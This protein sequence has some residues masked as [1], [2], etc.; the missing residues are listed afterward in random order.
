MRFFMFGKNML[1]CDEN[2]GNGNDLGGGEGE[3]DNSAEAIAAAA[4]KAKADEGKT[5]EEIKVA[6]DAAAE[7]AKAD[8]GKTPEEIKAAAEKAKADEGKTP[9]EIKAAEEAA[10]E[11]AKA[12]EEGKGAPENYEAFDLPAEYDGVIDEQTMEGFSEVAKELDLSQAQA[13][14]LVD[15]EVQRQENLIDAYQHQADKWTEESKTDDE[16][17]GADYELKQAKA[18]KAY[19]L[20]ATDEFKSLMNPYHAI[21][22]PKGL[23]L[24]NHPEVV[25]LFYR[26]G[27]KMSEDGLVVNDKGGES[28][29]SREEVMYG[30]TK[31]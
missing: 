13:Q 2:D 23:G 31:K 7:K 1:L 6:E 15:Y 16:I 14:K 30:N 27:L 5:T 22:N 25:R 19:D 29:L 28:K 4:E 21:D 20:L 9:E 12:D 3:V 26:V 11:K 17:G 24:G 10:A 8:E 18:V